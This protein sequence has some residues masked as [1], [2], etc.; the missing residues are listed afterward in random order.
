M[1]E[2][3]GYIP[4]FRKF[5]DHYLWEEDRE[6]SKAEAWID[7]IQMAR[8]SR[9][10]TKKFVGSKLIEWGYGQFPASIRFLKERWGWKSNTKVESFL[11]LLEAD[12]MI[13][14][15]KGQGQSVITL[16]KYSDYDIRNIQDKTPRGQGEDRGKTPRGQGED[17]DR[18]KQKEGK[19]GKER[20]EGN[21]ETEVDREGQAEIIYQAYP[22]K[23]GARKAKQKIRKTLEEVPFEELLIKVQLFARCV[24]GQDRQ[25]IPHP[26]TWFNQGRWQDDPEEWKAWKSQKSQTNGID[27]KRKT[28]GDEAVEFLT[29]NWN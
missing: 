13:K 20:E 5:F 19:E 6:F 7:C 29:G 12:G 27:H 4:L 26:E 11:S 14:V 21:K 23:V 15:D 18:T 22:R 17:T 24:E 1:T 10:K 9:K 3:T 25:F 28:K 16:C 2:E 8:Y